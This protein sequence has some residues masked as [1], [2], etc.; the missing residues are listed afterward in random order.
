[1]QR[2]ISLLVVSVMIFVLATGCSKR[3][4]IPGTIAGVGGVL[5][6]SGTIYRVTLDEGT[7]GIF[8]E[9]RE[10]Q[11]VTASLM[12]GGLALMLVGIIWSAT[13]TVCEEDHDCWVGDMC[14]KKSGTCVPRPAET[15]SETAA[16]EH[17]IDLKG[18]R[19]NLPV[20]SAL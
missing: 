3:Q 17:P 18:L 8:G 6:L 20:P 10:Q 7:E 4:V 15:P 1:M 9:T 16:L 13:G 14:D 12:L 2:F 19:L 5:F 11:G